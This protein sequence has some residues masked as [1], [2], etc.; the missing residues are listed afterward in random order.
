MAWILVVDDDVDI[1][2]ILKR[3]LTKEGH[4]VVCASNAAEA[5]KYSMCHAPDLV[6]LDIGLPD[7]NG[8]ELCRRLRSYPANATTPILFATVSNDI[9]SK[10]AAFDAGAD[11][12]LVKPFDLQELNLR[13]KVLLSHD[14]SRST[15]KNNSNQASG[16]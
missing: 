9:E 16:A 5:L 13:V 14:R 7:I 15:R 4:Q 6:L 1:L 2:K 10:I 8:V 3:D 12:Y 11:D